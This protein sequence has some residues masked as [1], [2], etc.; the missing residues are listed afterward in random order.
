MSLEVNLIKLKEKHKLN[1][2][3]SY[4]ILTRKLN[5]LMYFMK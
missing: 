1:I 2:K 5:E 4:I 3:L